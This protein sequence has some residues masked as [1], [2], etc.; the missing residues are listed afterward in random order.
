LGFAS[1]SAMQESLLHDE[2]TLPRLLNY[3]TVQVSEMFRD[4]AYYKALRRRV[5]PHLR[6]YP[7]LKVWVAG[8]SNGE[9]LY[10]LSILFREEVSARGRSS[11]RPISI[12]MPYGRRRRESIRST[13]YRNIRPI[14][15]SRARARR[16]LTIIRPTTGMPCSTRR[17]GAKSSFPTIAW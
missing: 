1:F 17:S 6:T 15:R 3:L 11:M 5:I 12:P 2:Q 9:E 10:S 16:Y 14:T 4:P 8:C 7:S 13:R